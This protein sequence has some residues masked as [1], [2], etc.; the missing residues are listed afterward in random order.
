MQNFPTGRTRS[1]PA[2][3]TDDKDIMNQLE[4]KESHSD[5]PSRTL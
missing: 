1:A 5:D 2:G 3:F 4:W